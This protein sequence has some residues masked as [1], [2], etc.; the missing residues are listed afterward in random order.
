M[1]VLHYRRLIL[2]LVHG[3]LLYVL[4]AMVV[5]LTGISIQQ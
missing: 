3:K 2:L 5:V 1:K 4:V